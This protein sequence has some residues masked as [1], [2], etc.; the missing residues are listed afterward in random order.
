MN[1]RKLSAEKVELLREVIS[2]YLP[3]D[4]ERLLSQSPESWFP[5]DRSQIRDAVGQELAG[6][7]FDENYE[8]NARGH[9][10]ESLIDFVNRLEL[11][12]KAN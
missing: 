3:R 12:P 8:P 9:M 1:T 4:A 6:T 10:L 7:G 11:L 5:T 2:K